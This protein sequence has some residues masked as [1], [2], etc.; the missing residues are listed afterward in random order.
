MSY[1][2]LHSL[3][4]ELRYSIYLEVMT[5]FLHDRRVANIKGLFFSCR[6]INQEMEDEYIGKARPLLSVV[7][8]WRSTWEEEGVEDLQ[9]ADSSDFKDFAKI[10][11]ISVTWKLFGTP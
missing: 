11:G 9:L 1:F 7:R 6:Q 3:P 8:D 10:T 4:A 5:L 2:D